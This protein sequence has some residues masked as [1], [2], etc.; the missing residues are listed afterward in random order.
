MRVACTL[1]I[2]LLASAAAAQ[3]TATLQGIVTDEQGAIVP[4]VSIVARSKATGLE[5][6]AVSDSAGQ[7]PF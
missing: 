5:R 3:S 1:F 7:V 2:W 4:G 6:T